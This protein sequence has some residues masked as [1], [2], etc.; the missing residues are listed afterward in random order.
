MNTENSIIFVDR[1]EKKIGITI[2]QFPPAFAI[3]PSLEG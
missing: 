3:N 2:K 1:S